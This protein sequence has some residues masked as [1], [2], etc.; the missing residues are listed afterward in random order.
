MPQLTTMLAEASPLFPKL[1]APNVEKIAY[2]LGGT[3]KEHGLGYLLNPTDPAS[4]D[5]DW[6][7]Q[8]WGDIVREDGGTAGGGQGSVRR[9]EECGDSG[10][11][12]QTATRGP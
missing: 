1:T 2:R 4:D 6:M 10:S 9:W 7:R 8:V 11:E 5:R 12:N 3:A